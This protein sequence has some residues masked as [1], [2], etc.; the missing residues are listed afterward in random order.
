[1]SKKR[2]S[3]AYSRKTKALIEKNASTAFNT[4]YAY[5][6]KIKV[7]FKIEF[8]FWLWSPCFT[9]VS[10]SVFMQKSFDTYFL[11]D[12]GWFYKVA[13][14]NNILVAVFG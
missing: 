9:N 12:E 13:N 10:G 5:Y 14:L 11:Q 2:R 1:M 6:V 3:I 8:Q 7:Y 4:N